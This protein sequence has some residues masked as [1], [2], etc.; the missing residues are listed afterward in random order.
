MYEE[1]LHATLVTRGRTNLCP[2]THRRLEMKSLATTEILI[3][4]YPSSSTPLDAQNLY[5]STVTLIEIPSRISYVWIS[6]VFPE[7]EGLGFFE[8]QKK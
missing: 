1:K 4:T 7:Q 5:S 3:F 2:R 6:S 8:E